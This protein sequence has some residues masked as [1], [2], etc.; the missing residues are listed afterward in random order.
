[1]D[2]EPTYY[3]HSATLRIFSESGL[4]FEEIERNLSLKPTNIHRKGERKGPRSPEYKH[5]M[6]MYESG[7]SEAEPLENH[8]YALWAALKPHKEYLISLK[9]QSTVD[10]FCGYRSNDHTTGIDVAYESLEIFRE[11]KIDFGLSIITT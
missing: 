7:L 2:E 8:L 11:L 1:M 3:D 6:W 10:I 9:Q 5:D 4:D